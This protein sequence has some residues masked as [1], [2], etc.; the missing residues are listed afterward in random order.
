MTVGIPYTNAIACSVLPTF[1]DEVLVHFLV[2]KSRNSAE[3]STKP[4]SPNPEISNVLN[5]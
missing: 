2:F 5:T 4:F 3:S 1:S